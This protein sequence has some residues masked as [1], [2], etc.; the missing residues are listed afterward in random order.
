LNHF[1]I[2]CFPLF[3]LVAK[4]FYCIHSIQWY[5]VYKFVLPDKPFIHMLCTESMT[6][7]H[8]CYVFRKFK[9]L[10]S[11]G[12][13]LRKQDYY[14]P[15]QCTFTRKKMTTS[16]V[17]RMG[18]Y[19][20]WYESTSTSVNSG[21]PDAIQMTSE[22]SSVGSQ[23][24]KKCTEE[25]KLYT[26]MYCVPLMSPYSGTYIMLCLTKKVIFKHPLL[27][28]RGYNRFSLY[29]SVPLFVD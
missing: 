18:T 1:A 25:K 20:S 29:L 22:S 13:S 17:A 3:I 27:G 14:T 26:I 9:S 28:I 2:G 15:F 23:G 4:D 21:S 10:G 5:R 6:T 8:I 7:L 12:F 16:E 24:E 19:P 11:S